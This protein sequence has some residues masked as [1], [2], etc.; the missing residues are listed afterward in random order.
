MKKKNRKELLLLF[1]M[2]T[3]IVR[4]TTRDAVRLLPVFFFLLLFTFNFYNI[5]RF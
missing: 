5:I 3:R 4:A 2:C 1:V